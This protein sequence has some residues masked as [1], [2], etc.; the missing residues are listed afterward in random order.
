MLEHKR[1]SPLKLNVIT[2]FTP[3][4]SV[5]Y[6]RN[7]IY[8][9]KIYYNLRAGIAQSVYCIG[10]RLD[11]QRTIRFL[12][13]AEPFIFVTESRS[14]LGPA[15]LLPQ[16]APW[17][18]SKGV[19]G[20][21]LKIATDIYLLLMSKRNE[22]NA[23]KYNEGK[24]KEDKEPWLH[25]EIFG[26]VS[27]NDNGKYTRDWTYLFRERYVLTLWSI[28]C[29]KHYKKSLLCS[30]GMWRIFCYP[31]KKSFPSTALNACYG[32][33]FIDCKIGLVYLNIN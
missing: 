8:E 4:A 13:E 17:T 32:N 9:T 24:S 15:E 14:F 16:W 6:T 31:D 3:F 19:K 30:L 11:G 12:A 5:A 29:F 27:C 25:Y 33:E 2:V 18:L 23:V 21:N 10:N 22:W 1:N 20:R 26:Y 28:T 7:L